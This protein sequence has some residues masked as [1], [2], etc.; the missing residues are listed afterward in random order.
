MA[1]KKLSKGVH[2]VNVKNC[3]GKMCQRTVR[4]LPNGQWRF[5]KSK[6]KK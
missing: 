6:K 1:R 4:V 2:I 5:M 3:K